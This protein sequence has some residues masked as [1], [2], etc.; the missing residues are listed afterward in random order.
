MDWPSL[1]NESAGAIRQSAVHRDLGMMAIITTESRLEVWDVAARQQVQNMQLE[2]DLYS[3]ISFS[4]D[5][6]KLLVGRSSDSVQ[7]IELSNRSVGPVIRHRLGGTR[8]AVH[9][10]GGHRWF[11]TTGANYLIEL[12]EGMR[13]PSRTVKLPSRVDNVTLS[14]D[15]Q[16]LVVAGLDGACY[17]IATEGLSQCQEIRGSRSEVLSFRWSADKMLA[18]NSVGTLLSIPVAEF[19]ES[20]ETEE[21]RPANGLAFSIVDKLGRV[22]ERASAVEI[23]E[24][25]S[26]LIGDTSGQVRLTIPGL[27]VPVAIRKYSPSITGLTLFENPRTVAVTHFNGRVNLISWQDIECRSNEVEQL[28]DLTDGIGLGRSHVSITGHASGK[29]KRWNTATGQLLDESQLHHAEI[30]SLSVHERTGRVA[31][32]AADWKIQLSDLNDLQP[33]HILSVDLGVRPVEFSR[34]GS[35]LAGAP[36]RENPIGLREGTVDL[37]DVKT[38]RSIKRLVGHSNWVIQI[39]FTADDSR[40]A[41]LALDGSTKIWSV[42]SGM[43]LNT[44]D[45]SK[46]A[47]PTQIQLLD[48]DRIAVAH[49]DGTI[50]I[51]NL[52]TGELLLTGQ[53]LNNRIGCIIS[54]GNSGCLIVS[55][56]DEPT[57]TC[58]D[59]NSLNLIAR[60]DSGTGDI[61]GLRTDMDW[62][63][64][65]I[66]GERGA[67]RIWDLPAT[68]IIPCE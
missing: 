39:Q 5:G 63:R 15:G 56:D 27:D 6:R 22:D 53:I 23:A 55:S 68:D 12:A 41:T 58:V 28:S 40:L 66:L 30:F 26:L 17:L 1:R 49:A 45:L 51:H 34:S 32:M 29:L 11:V 18:V 31:T 52:M 4:S 62:R 19:A 8:D 54:P 59:A 35:L 20:G 57:L 38:G 3:S 21:V 13:E 65:Q 44:I 50:G 33:I 37:W 9:D 67:I 61:I 25:D 48:H 16:W 47:T 24:N 36:S 10:P 60:L 42:E 2:P 7:V 46:F 64:V 14:S 43:C